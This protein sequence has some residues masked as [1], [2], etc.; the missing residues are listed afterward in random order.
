MLPA[1]VSLTFIAW[2]LRLYAIARQD[3]WG[4]EAFSIWLSS[5][6]LRA[7][8]AGGA[9]THPPLYPIFLWFWMRGVGRTPL[10]VRALSA[11]L[12]L[13]IIPLLYAIGRR[14]SGRRGAL[15]AALLGAFS[16]GLIYYAQETRMYSLAACLTAASLLMTV[17]LLRGHNH[18]R[19]WTLFTMTA[20][21][22]LYTHYDTA[23]L[24]I[25]EALVLLIARREA[26]RSF[27]LSWGAIGVAYLPWIIVQF[28]FLEGKAHA[29][30]EVLTLATL[31]EIIGETLRLLF[32]GMPTPS[33]TTAAVML[34]AGGA[35]TLTG[36]R[37][38][39]RRGAAGRLALLAALLPFGFAWLINPLMPF[40]YPRYL[41]FVAVPLFVVMGAAVDI[42]SRRWATAAGIAL[43]LLAAFTLRADWDYAHETS[44]VRGRYGQMMAYVET[45]ARPGDALLLANPLQR[46]IFDYYRPDA[47]PAFFLPRLTELDAETVA[48]LRDYAHHYH[49]LWLVRYGNPAEYDPQDIL[50]HWL[51]EHGTLAYHG[52]WLDAELYLFVIS[53]N[54][55]PTVQTDYRF[56]EVIHL[57]GYTLGATTLRPGDTLTITLFWTAS[58][59]PDERYTVYTHLLAPD[60]HIVAQMDGEPQGGA[61]P[62]DRWSPGERI[63][64]GY[65]ILV[66][67]ETPAG[68]YHVR[69]GLYRLE[70]GER[71]PVF[72]KHG[73]PIGDGLT[74]GEITIAP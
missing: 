34:I 35:I 2:A 19:D 65:A 47:P 70:T 4:D 71:L 68:R 39:W 23:F 43:A 30:F 31:R 53:G 52:G 33:P 66:P 62:T 41:L 20:L 7:A 26:W 46:A 58:A 64:D 69:I 11:L 56:G 8:I 28:S 24:I 17:R 37:W 13:L 6:P 9:D 18:P 67:E 29:R 54:D 40:F 25:A 60:R 59:Q 61:A 48:M 1:T 10:A 12:G 57:R 38:L 42:P 55:R 74:L 22:A 73:E 51:A 50:V 49:R 72:D 14:V 15:A 63:R 44:L 16:P 5:Q 21:A 27:L 36:G 45:H 32:C 3:I